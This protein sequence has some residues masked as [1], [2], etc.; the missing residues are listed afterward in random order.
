M[1]DRFDLLPEQIDLACTDL[2]EAARRVVM[3]TLEAARREWVRCTATL[4][5]TVHD[6]DT[7]DDLEVDDGQ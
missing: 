6:I 5:V 2:P 3:T 4:T 7:A 1:A